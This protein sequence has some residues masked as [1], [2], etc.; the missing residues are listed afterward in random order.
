M[1]GFIRWVGI[2]YLLFLAFK[3]IKSALEPTV[4]LLTVKG[5]QNSS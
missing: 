4:L 3:L 2:L 5:V 1:F